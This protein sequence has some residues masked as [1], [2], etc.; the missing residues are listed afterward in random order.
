MIK[1]TVKY[2]PRGSDVDNVEPF[3]EVKSRIDSS[4]LFGGSSGEGSRVY[5]PEK[6]GFA[7]GELYYVFRGKV[8]TLPILR[9]MVKDL[10]L[11]EISIQEV[12]RIDRGVA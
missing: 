1:V 4:R 10:N 6:I 12:D 7:G 8:P 5:D 11:E 2:K 3:L 9:D